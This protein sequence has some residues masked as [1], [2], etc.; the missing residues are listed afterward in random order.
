MFLEMIFHQKQ[1]MFLKEEK[2]KIDSKSNWTGE[3]HD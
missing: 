1:S 3:K 2:S